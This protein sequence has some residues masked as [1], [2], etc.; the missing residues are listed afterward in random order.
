MPRATRYE[1]QYRQ[2]GSAVWS[3]AILSTSPFIEVSL[4]V[5]V[6]YQYRVRTICG[7]TTTDWSYTGVN[8]YTN[9]NTCITPAGV[10]VE[11]VQ[12]TYDFKVYWTNTG[13]VGWNFRYRRQGDLSWNTTTLM[14]SEVTLTNLVIGATYEY[15][16]QSICTGSVVSEWGNLGNFTVQ[17]A[18]S[19]QSCPIDY[20][21]EF[22]GT[23]LARK[24][25]ANVVNIS[26]D[27]AYSSSDPL[28]SAGDF[29]I[30]GTIGLC[31]SPVQDTVIAIT[32]P[33]FVGELTITAAGQLNLYI[34][35]FTGRP[36]LDF[37]LSSIAF[38]GA[39]GTCPPPNPSNN[40]LVGTVT[41]SCSTGNSPQ[42]GQAII[43]INF[44]R[45]TPAAVTILIGTLEQVLSNTVYRGSDIFSPP[46]G[47]IPGNPTDAAQA[48][49]LL[50]IPAGVTAFTSSGNIVQK[51][52][53][54]DGVH[55]W[56][57]SGTRILTD[58]YVKVDSP[59]TL[60][61]ALALTNS[62]ITL[63]NL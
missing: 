23:L 59:T 63:H 34:E 45:P 20:E 53:G 2:V 18:T 43:S 21:D 6:S 50:N 49:F 40:Q 51:G 11:Q 22:T 33:G 19:S 44:A 17:N 27:I 54:N 35:S 60:T 36:S 57:C 46:P 52:Y 38:Q 7:T 4:T 26:G 13:V 28:P 1:F 15:Q 24:S 56:T 12:G 5:G 39:P 47:A 31:C 25:S 3:P 32:A 42:Q 37:T 10:T 62:G 16:V 58:L 61:A 55:V 9:A 8:V 30:V 29:I 48:P 14:V 41:Y